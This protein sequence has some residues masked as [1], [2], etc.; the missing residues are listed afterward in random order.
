[1]LQSRYFI[2]LLVLPLH[3][4]ACIVLAAVPINPNS[5]FE[6]MFIGAILGTLYSQTTI[7]VAW[8][9]LGPG[10]LAVRLPLSLLWIFVMLAVVGIALDLRGEPAGIGTILAYSQGTQWIVAQLPF[11][12]IAFIFRLRLRHFTDPDQDNAP[13]GQFGIAQLMI[14]TGIVGVIL[15]LGRILITSNVLRWMPDREMPI[16]FFLVGVAIVMTIP[17]VFAAFL[18]RYAV[19]A[20]LV[21]IV[22][23]VAITIAELPLL[24]ATVGRRGGP[25]VMHL[26]WINVFTTA[27]VLLHVVATRLAGYQF[28][29]ADRLIG[30]FA[31]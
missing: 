21:A 14:I 10:P 3:L 11:W 1:M 12:T 30:E 17:L 5:N 24:E 8:T 7:A 19:W 23:I 6:H 31:E 26:V 4:T 20:V 2:L 16:F 29:F 18:S 27:W 25:D 28:S 9:A 13:R 22:F 15:G